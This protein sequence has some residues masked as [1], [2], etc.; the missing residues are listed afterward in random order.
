MFWGFVLRRYLVYGVLFGGFH[1]RGGFENIQLVTGKHWAGPTCRGSEQIGPERGKHG[2]WQI[3]VFFL[4]GGYPRH[5][6]YHMQLFVF[7]INFLK[8]T[9]T[10]R[11]SFFNP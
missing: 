7:G 1:G 5:Q 8:I 2:F 9:I 3:L 10:I 6:N 11:I 4:G